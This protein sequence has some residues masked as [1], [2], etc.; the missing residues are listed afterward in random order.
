MGWGAVEWAGE[1]CG[2]SVVVGMAAA[3][4]AACAPVQVCTA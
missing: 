4:E 1:V 2:G 3:A